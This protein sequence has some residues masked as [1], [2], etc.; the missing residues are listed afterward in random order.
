MNW[1]RQILF[2]ELITSNDS[3]INWWRQMTLLRTDDVKWLCRE[4]MTSNDSVVNRWRQM[5]LSWTDDVK[6]LCHE[7]MTSNNSV[8]NWWS[9]W[10]WRW[11]P[12]WSSRT[13]KLLML[14]WSIKILQYSEGL[15]KFRGISLRRLRILRKSELSENPDIRIKHSN[16]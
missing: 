14:G 5:T 13:A 3:V 15:K 6:W 4:P 10:S 7:L 1:W 8:M 2:Y 16:M 12:I 9:Q 11:W